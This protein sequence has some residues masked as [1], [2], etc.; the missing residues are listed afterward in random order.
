M[1]HNTV[2][3]SRHLLS[4]R[5]KRQLCFMGALLVILSAGGCGGGTAA[6]S[7]EIPVQNQTPVAD[8]ASADFPPDP[9]TRVIARTGPIRNIRVGETAIL[10]GSRSTSSSSE[11]LTYA[12]S[13]SSRP[14][15][16]DAVIQGPELAQPDFIADV[17]GTYRAQ[18]IVSSDGVSSKRAVSVIVATVPPE[19]G[20]FHDG[21]SPN[22]SNCHNE[23]FVDI[24]DKAST[25]L[26]TSN[27][28]ETCHS[29]LGFSLVSFVD[30]LEIFGECSE[31]HNGDLA[32]GKS[33]F[34]IDTNAECDNC[35]NTV[36]FLDLDLDGGFDH[37]GILSSCSGCHNGAVS[38]GKTPSPPHPET[39]SEC[40]ECHTTESF[41]NA[42]PDHSGP[43]VL[44]VRCDSCHGV[45]AT[46]PVVAHPVV[47]VDCATCHST[48]TFSMG[49][50][51]NHRV[52]DALSQSCESCHND[53]TNIG[54]PTKSSAPTHPATFEDC[55]TCHSTDSFALG[56]F[57]HSGIVSDCA[58]C[59]GVTASGKSDNHMPTM[60]DC[61][62]C[63]TP[64]AFSTG[65]YDHAGV[66][67]GCESCHDNS[68]TIGKLS[69]HLPTNADCADCHNIVD[70]ADTVFNHTGIDTAN[71]TACHD[72]SISLGKPG[73]HVPTD[74]D[75][76]ACHDIG[77]FETFAGIAYSHAGIDPDNCA[78]CHDAGIATPKPSSHIPTQADCSVCHDYTDS[79]VFSNF[80]STI[81]P[82]I[83]A[84]CGGCHVSNVFPLRPELTKTDEHLPTS[85]DCSICHM[86]TTFAPANFDHTGITVQCSSCHD[87]SSAHVALGASGKTATP[88]HENTSGDCAV[89]HNTLSFA[90]AFV[91]HSSAEVTTSRCD[92]CH[93]GTNATGKSAK[94]DHVLTS[95]D[96]GSCHVPGGSFAPAVFSHDGIVDNCASCHNGTD[97]TG[98]NAKVDPPHIPISEDCS[99]CHTPTVFANANFDHLG[100]TDNCSSC[101]NGTTAMGKSDTHVPTNADCSDCHTTAGFLPG[102]FDHSGIVDNCASC[103]D[104]G[105]A[106]GKGQGHLPTSQD[107]GVCHNPSS[108]VPA[109]FDHTGITDNCA[110]CHGVS[111]VGM[112][113]EHIPTAL[114]C[115]QC[116]TTA[117]FAGALFDHQGITDG[118]STCH[119]GLTAAGS[120]P[121]GPNDHFIT[122][123]QCNDCHS[124]QGWAPIDF[125][126]TAASDYPGDHSSATGCRD[127][128][129]DNDENIAYRF[130]QYAP[131]CAAC[132][133]NDF[134]RKGDHIGGENGTVSQNRDCSGGGRGCHRVSDRTFD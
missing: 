40:G 97:A 10:D 124:P 18:L 55:G 21:L 50:I 91:D 63:H 68:I 127:C 121:Q 126:H 119:D 90:D 26:A 98:T 117:T 34:H 74:L 76:S 5:L 79:F 66:V 113:P 13:F 81:H 44:N 20:A 125:T 78:S 46:G 30:H 118:C 95:L 7:T 109:T 64:G 32:L 107:C 36:H 116:H 115:S 94:A 134:E 72:S 96:C 80:A 35:H 60:D 48:V 82:D 25:H 108:F 123:A 102:S 6:E 132:H 133:A 73:N 69:N 93:D 75:C 110:S 83:S 47:A 65:T 52:V 67:S 130:S 41:V 31:C 103:H 43:A 33:E 61:S 85:Q 89:C 71:C 8:N 106:T 84:G 112:P 38:T 14:D 129:E 23:G 114:D 58:S 29:P 99:A 42:F 9:V 15:G 54:A 122:M 92:T 45:S 24:P 19:S 37:S 2:A 104:A 128:H 111:A 59:H 70:F 62:V 77:N 131:D 53:A 57:D 120:D 88:I 105:F 12:W 27:T 100:I 4:V 22:C 86:N 39:D 49:G 11:P 51:F 101:H 3:R 28:C 16:S 56:I 87:G 1:R 17:R